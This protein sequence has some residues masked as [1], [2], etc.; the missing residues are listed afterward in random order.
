[1]K[2][3]VREIITETPWG[4]VQ[5]HG[6]FWMAEGRD[7]AFRVQLPGKESEPDR[8][9]VCRWAQ[10]LVVNLAFGVGTGG[11]PLTW[12]VTFTHEPDDT[13]FILFDFAHKGEVRL[14]CNEIELRTCSAEQPGSDDAP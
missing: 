8:L 4:D 11:Y 1:M 14:R 2:S 12:D 5:L 7:V 3:S 9:L 10:E 13:L 6:L